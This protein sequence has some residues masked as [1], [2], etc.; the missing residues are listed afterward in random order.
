[1]KKVLIATLLFSTLGINAQVISRDK[2][3]DGIRTVATEEANYGK[4]NLSKL[5]PSVGYCGMQINGDNII[6]E[7][8]NNNTKID[9]TFSMDAKKD[10]ATLINENYESKMPGIL[11]L[12]VRTKTRGITSSSVFRMRNAFL[13]DLVKDHDALKKENNQK[14]VVAKQQ[15]AQQKKIQQQTEELI[16]AALMARILNNLLTPS[17][18]NNQYY[19]NGL[20]FNNEADME[21]YKN[22][23]GLK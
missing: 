6:I 5:T 3:R 8:W 12:F 18:S 22:A 13:N 16:Y 4:Y 19:Y 20:Y 9:I 7:V 11:D 17:S 1:M 15:Q 10:M 14:K 21:D 2:T 23:N